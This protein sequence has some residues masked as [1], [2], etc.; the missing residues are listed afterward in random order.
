MNYET[1]LYIVENGIATI[2]LNRPQSLNAFTDVMLAETTAAFQQADE[3]AS[4]RCIVLTGSGRGFCSGQ[5]L[6]EIRNR[7]PEVTIGDH[8]RHGYHPLIKQMVQIEKPI[9]GAI[10]GVAAGAG[11]SLALFTDFRIASEKA[12][13]MLAFSKVGLVP[14]SGINWLL[15]RLIGQGRAYQMALT[16]ERIPA[17]VAL[18]WGMINVVAV[19]EEFAATV[20]RWAQQFANGAT[21]AYG[22]AKRAMW[23]S[24]QLDLGQA[25][26]LEADL[27]SRAGATADFHEGV[28]AF[29][30]KRSAT[31]HGA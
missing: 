28:Q 1:I 25:L 30:E 12:S 23:Q 9:I 31:F 22:L 3:D 20:Q 7:P 21:R 8:L 18:A 5:D 29:R 10:N 6:A 14:D 27:Q 2:T 13:F 4:V 24:W 16:A 26:E 11:C 17:T 19:E 15:P